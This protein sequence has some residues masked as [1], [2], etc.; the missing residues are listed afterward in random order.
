MAFAGW[1]ATAPAASAQI[2]FAPCGQSNDFA[3]GHLTVA[4]DP[5]GVLPG[6]VTLAIR[7]HR[8]PVGEARSAIIALAGGPGQPAIPFAEEFKNC[9]ARL[10]R[11]AI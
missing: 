11:H 3:C 2:A 7:R 10:R 1:A 8:A 5:L 6:T 9:S 4:L